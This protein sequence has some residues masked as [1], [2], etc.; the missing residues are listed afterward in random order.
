M[1]SDVIALSSS[2]SRLI[3][4]SL[5][6][7]IW[8]GQWVVMMESKPFLIAALTSNFLDICGCFYLCLDKRLEELCRERIKDFKYIRNNIPEGYEDSDVDF[9]LLMLI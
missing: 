6:I 2:P 1:S 4:Q 7:V 9:S 3:R 5:W 8:L